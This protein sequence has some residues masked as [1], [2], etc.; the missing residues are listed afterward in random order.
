M[1]ER[2]GNVDSSRRL[3]GLDQ[4]LVDRLQPLLNYEVY[5]MPF[6]G[7][8]DRVEID[9]FKRVDGVNR[10]IGGIKIY[11]GE[12]V[13]YKNEFGQETVSFNGFNPDMLGSYFY[14]F[15]SSFTSLL[16]TLTLMATID[17]TAR[18]LRED[19]SHLVRVNSKTRSYLQRFQEAGLY[20]YCDT[21]GR[22]RR[23]PTVFHGFGLY[24]CQY[25]IEGLD[26][27]IGK[28]AIE[29]AVRGIIRIREEGMKGHR[30][31]LLQGFVRNLMPG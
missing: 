5:V 21:R 20:H 28:F 26:S 4:R 13:E 25:P 1:G 12:R 23:E 9:H 18:V 15:G 30:F 3:L 27:V 6:R 29:E 8:P 2:L 7:P 11:F 31:R 10:G 16:M 19:L 17:R 14:S 24:V 22:I